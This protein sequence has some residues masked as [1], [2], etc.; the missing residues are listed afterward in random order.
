MTSHLIFGGI[1]L[2]KGT[3]KNGAAVIG[4]LLVAPIVFCRTISPCILIAVKNMGDIKSMD[5]TD[6]CFYSVFQ[7]TCYSLEI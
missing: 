5:D 4:S 2:R 7:V 1:F 3:V 6:T